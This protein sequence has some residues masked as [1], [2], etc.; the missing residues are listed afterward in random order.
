MFKL[1]DTSTTT[2]TLFIFIF[3]AYLFS[4]AIRFIWVNEISSV[5]QFHWNNELMINNN[6][7][8]YFAQWAQYLLNDTAVQ[9]P[10]GMVTPLA[11]LTA[12]LAKIL[13]ISFETLILY[14]PS[15]IGSLIVVPLILI[16]RAL[17]QTTLGFIAALIG[18]IAHSYYNRTMTGY[19]DT[20][21]LNIVFPVLEMYTLILALTHQRNHYLIPITVSIALYQWWYPQAYALDTALFGMIVGF[22]LIFDRKNLYFYK[23]ALFILLGILSI[24]L[25]SKISLAIII[26]ALFHFKKE[27]SLK[28]FWPLF[29]TILGVYFF[30][31][32][33]DPI[34]EL[35]KGYVFRGSTEATAASSTLTYY[36]VMSTVR[37][38]GHIPFTLFAERISGH[39]ITF[40]LA[41]IGYLMAVIAYRPLLV[42]LPLLGLGFIAMS[43]GL[44]FTIYAVPVM[45]IGLAYLIIYFS[46]FIQ[47][48]WLR[49]TATVVLT[50]GALYPNYA[51]IKEYIMPT[52][53]T[54]NEVEALDQLGKIASNKD[55]VVA[56]WDYGYP[57]RYYGNIKTWIDGGKHSGDVNYP[58][59]FT[60]TAKDSISAAHMMRLYTEYTGKNTTTKNDFEYML[61]KEGYK[62]PNDFVT[63][64]ALP[65]YKIPK[66]T[67]DVYLYLPLR[68][69]E[70]FPTVA[71]FSNLDLTGKN[72][73]QQPFFYTT[74]SVQDTGQTIELGQGLSII[75]ATSTLKIGAQSLPIKSFYQ[76]GYDPHQKVHVSQQN[77]ASE[78]LSVIYLASYQQF[79]VLD[80]YYLK[81][82]YIQMFVFEQYDKSLFEPV[83][84]SPMTKIFK[85]KI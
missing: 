30:T 68:M 17:N 31:G 48:I 63:A 39:V 14:M 52:V 1:D 44:R 12:A 22:A 35:L 67:R 10:D 78:G 29:A 15:F 55:T 27:L 5:P 19:Y 64:L 47:I 66:K 74:R 25:I 85:L 62:D 38:A 42:T 50:I 4:V 11:Y 26:F 43:S 24:P 34:W 79:L 28:L 82:Q 54:T 8:Y 72:Q 59:S 20:D 57:I 56:W 41:C 49:H 3:I 51:H 6:D 46:R 65:D 40:A 83:I 7:G 70:I 45:A 76:V 13:P 2:K 21:M 9:Q 53:M 69:M 33:V 18:S 77:F 60:L 80:D 81:S 23:I 73:P 16:G 71:L 36:N 84:L 75:K 58:A 37:E 32:G 61:E